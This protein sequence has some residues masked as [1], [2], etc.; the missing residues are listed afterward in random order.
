[1]EATEVAV[2]AQRDAEEEMVVEEE[3]EGT[4]DRLMAD[5]LV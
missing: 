2:A 5:S 4:S 1:V 3:E